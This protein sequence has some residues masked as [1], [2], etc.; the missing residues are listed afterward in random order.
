MQDETQTELKDSLG[1]RELY[2]LYNVG[3]F[4]AWSIYFPYSTHGKYLFFG[5]EADARKAADELQK[6]KKHIYGYKL[7]E[8][9][10]H[11]ENIN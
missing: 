7:K 9:T 3:S 5:S 8:F 11:I 10:K 6:E 4:R 2:G 1:H